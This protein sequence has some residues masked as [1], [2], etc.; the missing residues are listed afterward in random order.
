MGKNYSVSENMSTLSLNNIELVRKHCFSFYVKHSIMYQ[1][2]NI[3]I[4]YYF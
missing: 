3:L 4:Y 2:S 1:F